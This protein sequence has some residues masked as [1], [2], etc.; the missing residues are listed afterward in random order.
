MD[1]HRPRLV[2]V[3]RPTPL[4]LLVERHGTLAQARFY[5]ESRGQRL[6]G[7]QDAHQRLSAGLAQVMAAIPPDRRRARVER[8][9]LDRFLFAPDDVVLVVGQD[10]LVAN[11]AKYL[12][13]QLTIGINPDPARYDGVLCPHPPQAL[14]ALLRWLEQ[15]TGPAF[16]IEQRVMAL[17]EREDGQRLL[18]LNE[19][20]VGHRTHQS[21]RYRLRVAGQEQRQSS[22]GL[23]CTTGTGSTGWAKSIA[24]QRNLEAELPTPE[25]PRLCW[26]VREPFPSVATGVDL[27][28]GQLGPGQQLELSSELGDNGVIFADGIESDYLDFLDGQTVRLGLAEQTLRLV[29]PT[30]SPR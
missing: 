30:N 9:E 16:R 21:A 10:G 11:V 26:F 14:P 1:S 20:F 6:D 17:A 5:L 13:G 29:V 28:F 7:Y 3:T 2:L 19:I 25:E 15:P 23:I 24:R 22:S 8:A 4:E 12:G 18:A 27:D